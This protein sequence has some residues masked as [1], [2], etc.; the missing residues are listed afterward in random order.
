MSDNPGRDSIEKGAVQIGF[1][2]NQRGNRVEFEGKKAFLT[3]LQVRF[4]EEVLKAHPEP[5]PRSE[6]ISAVWGNLAQINENAFDKSIPRLNRKLSLLGLAIK[7]EPSIGYR[8]VRLEELPLDDVGWEIDELFSEPSGDETGNPN[9]I[10]LSS[11]SAIDFSDSAHYSCPFLT[12]SELDR[13]I[14]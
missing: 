3:D 9:A 2:G 14:G 5:A 11:T 6:I 1:R 12:R 7:N 13:A 4:L 8:I 10:K